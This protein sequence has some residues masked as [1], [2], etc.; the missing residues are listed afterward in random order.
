MNKFLRIG[1]LALAIGSFSA[2]N[3]ADIIVTDSGSGTGTTTWTSD[4]VYFLDGFV[5]VNSGQVL[6]IQAGTVIKGM[7]GTGADASALVVARGGQL[8][9]Q[10]TAAAPIIFTAESDPL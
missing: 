4:N 1:A 9:A 8:F 10:G 2:V 3:A 6:T 7:P 5:F